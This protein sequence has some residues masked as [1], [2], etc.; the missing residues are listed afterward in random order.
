M[1]PAAGQVP[2]PAAAPATAALSGH[3]TTSAAAAP[4]G[5]AAPEP[6]AAAPPPP[7]DGP[8]ATL[9]D[10]VWARGALLQLV[11]LLVQV[12]Q[13]WPQE[14]E[15]CLQQPRSVTTAAATSSSSNSSNGVAA[16]GSSDGRGS[17]ERSDGQVRSI[18]GYC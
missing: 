12:L 9:Q 8:W 13:G 18:V 11:E 6:P 7:P 15:R 3:L 4:S 2:A 17:G 10:L 1:S 16:P 5:V 14:V